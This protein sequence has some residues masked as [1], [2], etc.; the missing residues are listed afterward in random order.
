MP[1]YAFRDPL[2][3]ER[4]RSRQAAVESDDGS[5]SANE[6]AEGLGCADR[7]RCR[8]KASSGFEFDNHPREEFFQEPKSHDA[9]LAS[10]GSDDSDAESEVGTRL[11]ENA[12]RAG[13]GLLSTL[14]LLETEEEAETRVR[15]QKDAAAAYQ[16]SLEAKR[17]RCERRDAL[18]KPAS[19]VRRMQSQPTP[20]KASEGPRP[21]PT[22]EA[23]SPSAG[24]LS[25]SELTEISRKLQQLRAAAARETDRSSSSSSSSSS[26]A[27]LVLLWKL[28][29]QQQTT[30]TAKTLKATGLGRELNEGYWKRHPRASVANMARTLVARWRE[31][32]RAE[33]RQ[34]E[35]S[36]IL[37]A[38]SKS[39]ARTTT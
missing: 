5:S 14:K 18:R 6:Y 34:H 21:R 8:E 33:Q 2:R 31:G 13:G 36:N 39:M 11:G 30:M 27:A 26:D 15:N 7:K 20:A 4:S 22:R 32:Y 19:E 38:A 25:V 10:D 28:E 24:N 17:R 16:R 29:Q 12:R 37:V 3:R 23:A 35:I 1:A 9:A